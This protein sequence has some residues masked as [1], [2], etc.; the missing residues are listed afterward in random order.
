MNVES[1]IR[2]Y[3]AGEKSEA[4]LILAAG[5]AA[6]LTALWLWFWIREPFARGLAASLLLTAALG[7]GVGGT[8]Y[9]RTDGQM[10]Q[11]AAQYR[12][13]PVRFATDEGTRMQ[14]VVR[15]FG[16]Y[17][18]AYAV[19]V[20]AALTLVFLIGSAASHGVAVGLLILAALGFTIDFYAEARA[21]LYL[22]DLSSAGAVAP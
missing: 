20:G 14:Q 6:L 12:D 10:R 8:V 17:R 7:L 16:Y 4:A 18:V 9:F 11:L 2:D 15:S 3:F 19:A 5:M 22:R 21:V 1:V 13:A